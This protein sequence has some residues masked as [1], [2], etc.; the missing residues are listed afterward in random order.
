MKL[1]I[2]AASIALACGSLYA[3]SLTQQAFE[4]GEY[5]R[6]RAL[7]SVN[8]SAA[9]ARGYTGK[10]SVIAVLDSGIDVNH[11]EFVNKILMVKD[12]SNSGTIADRVGHGTY[13]AG[14]A[15][16][17]KNNIG[18][19]GVAYDAKLIVGKVT[20][21]GV[22]TSTN[23][24]NA[25]SWAAQTGA[26]VAN[27]S[28]NFTLSSNNLKPTL[29]APGVYKTAYTNTGN[30]P[31]SFNATQWRNSIPGDM[32]IVVASGNDGT[33]WSGGLSQLATATDSNGN[34][35]LGGR[36]IIA[37]NWNSQT[38][39]GTGS[40]NNGA[41]HLCM[42]MTN[43]VC[44]DKYRMSDFY[45]LA[46]GVGITS[47]D[48]RARSGTSFA[49]PTISGGVAIIHQMWPQMTGANVAKL[50]LSTGNKNIAGYNV[51][52]H[53]QGLMDLDRATR[54]VGMVGIPT[55]GRL[56]G[57]IIPGADPLLLTGGSASTGG[58]TG[59]MVVD[60]FQRDFYIKGKAF[61]AV[62]KALDFNPKQASMPYETK[63]LYTQFNSYV[64][65][66]HASVNNFEMSIYSDANQ[67]ITAPTMFETAYTVKTSQGDIRL[68]G[69]TFTEFNTWLGN[70]VNSFTGSARNT[71]SATHFL[72][73]G[74][75][76]ELSD[77]TVYANMQHGFT[78]TNANS[79]NIAKLGTVRSYSWTL[80]AEHK[81]TKNNS[82][83]IMAYQPVS[84]YRAEAELVA[85]VGL[86]AQFNIIQHST[87]NLAADV[88]ET[89]LG[90]YHKFN[91]SKEYSTLAFI[92]TRQNF[93]GQEGVK[94]NAV[95]FQITRQF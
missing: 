43:N 11:A 23:A 67:M 89:R 79:A 28:L 45:L 71:E 52:L 87:V 64:D 40:G 77:T 49:A 91:D 15:A 94:D 30:L 25:A 9:Y 26:D 7:P 78:R 92:E 74:Y 8:A 56:S 27:M 65:R 41:A 46:P 31:L 14:V 76:K 5:G 81:L 19:H 36:M 48:T 85:P 47:I 54:P 3:Q 4:T 57:P 20:N 37:G 13:V 24:L 6:S 83:G 86:D 70:S 2:L 93:K 63:N 38:N 10:G 84:V 82:V 55:T 12:F 90:L 62:T 88:K 80:G 42:V 33:A 72:G 75:S 35:M 16:A 60:D 95:G 34:L 22:I 58:L 44:Q 59:I 29:I 66:T 69:G 73:L 1:K 61:T 17:A 18:A 50:L 68:S 53:G 32:V 21:T 51:V 39:K